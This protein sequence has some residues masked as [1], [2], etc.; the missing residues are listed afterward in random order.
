M[1]TEY[2]GMAVCGDPFQFCRSIHDISKFHFNSKLSE[3]PKGV[4]GRLGIGTSPAPHGQVNIRSLR[5]R[6]LLFLERPMGME[7]FKI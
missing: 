6:F 2:G 4:K 7:R 1:V 5:H 3:D